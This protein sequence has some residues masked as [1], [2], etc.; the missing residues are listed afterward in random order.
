VSPPA[1]AIDHFLFTSRLGFCE[2]YAAATAFLLRAAGIPTRLVGGYQGGEVNPYGGYLVVRQSDAHAWCEV[3][4]DGSWQ[5]LDPTAVVAPQ[6]LQSRVADLFA[7]GE[8]GDFSL[9]GFT[10]L[11]RWLQP[12]GDGWDL[13]N[14]RWNL[15]VM[16]YSFASQTRL[17]SQIGI[18]FGLSKGMVQAALLA[19]V[20]LG[21]VY[22]LLLALLR[23][24]SPNLIR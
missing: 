10:R 14:S 6:R 23:G 13:I 11:P 8:G 16:Q 15:W 2:H 12:L 5:R 20:I 24:G 17:F 7:E 21:A 9:L 4:L 18:D 22:F 1:D 3:L 19:V